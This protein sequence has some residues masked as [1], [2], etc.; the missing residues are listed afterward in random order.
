MYCVQCGLRLNGGARYCKGCGAATKRSFYTGP[1]EEAGFDARDIEQNK[2]IAALAYIPFLFFLPLVSCPESR[3][4]RYHA[5]QG[6]VFLIVTM[7][8]SAIFGAISAILAFIW[9]VG[10][11]I[12]ALLS[13]SWLLFAAWFI[14]GIV[15]ALGGRARPLPIIGVLR[16]L[17]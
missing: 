9:F 4:A 13:L 15:N 8:W 10:P 2:A 11:I 7:I 16:I 1:G 5:N 17:H 14:I 6:L 3:F 12:I